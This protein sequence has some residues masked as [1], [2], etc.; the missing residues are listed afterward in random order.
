MVSRW[1]AALQKN[2]INTAIYVTEQN[3]G[4]SCTQLHNVSLTTRLDS[5]NNYCF[6]DALLH[7]ILTQF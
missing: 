2:K 1:A 3:G 5:K 6:K 4:S 7:K